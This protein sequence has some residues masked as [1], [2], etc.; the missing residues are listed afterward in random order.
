MNTNVYDHC[1]PV[2]LRGLGLALHLKKK[3]KKEKEN[4]WK[5]HFHISF[6]FGWSTYDLNP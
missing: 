3:K 4:I 6:W 5:L 2:K 1:G